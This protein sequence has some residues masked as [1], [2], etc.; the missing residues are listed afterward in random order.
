MNIFH[1]PTLNNCPTLFKCDSAL[2]ST[3][4]YSQNHRQ[5]LNE[6]FVDFKTPLNVKICIMKTYNP[7]PNSK[8]DNC[9]SDHSC[10]DMDAKMQNET[11]NHAFACKL[12]RH[13]NIC[14]QLKKMAKIVWCSQIF[15][16][17]FRGWN[18]IKIVLT[19]TRYSENF[20]KSTES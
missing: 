12:L 9:W 4:E 6:K 16:T 18:K 17:K 11:S 14:L 1:K 5:Q 2:L 13:K 15:P 20:M 3:M 8:E 19:V 7:I 10:S